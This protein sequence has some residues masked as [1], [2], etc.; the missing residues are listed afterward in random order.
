MNINREQL[1]RI[2]SV[3]AC[4]IVLTT[5]ITF[6]GCNINKETSKV[7]MNVTI[8][9]SVDRAIVDNLLIAKTTEDILLLFCPKE[10]G[11]CVNY[12]TEEFMFMYRSSEDLSNKLNEYFYAEVEV[13]K[14][15]PYL[16]EKYGDKESYSYN[17]VFTVFNSLKN[18]NNLHIKTK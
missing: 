16:V 11:L 8:R 2:K 10:R 12:E 18:D 3:L 14:L 1:Q 15:K 17:E 7:D 4:G 9:T 6:N 5:A 13:E